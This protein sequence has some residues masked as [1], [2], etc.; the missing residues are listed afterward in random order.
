METDKERIVIRCNSLFDYLTSGLKKAGFELVDKSKTEGW[1]GL[2]WLTYTYE[3]TRGKWS[4]LQKNL[5]YDLYIVFRILYINS[6][7]PCYCDVM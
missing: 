7:N 2:G 5:Y 1:L 4:A 3:L 6:V